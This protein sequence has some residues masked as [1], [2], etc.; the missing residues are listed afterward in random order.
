[1]IFGRR[2]APVLGFLTL[3]LTS[4]QTPESIIGPPEPGIAYVPSVREKIAIE[5][6]VKRKLKDPGSAVIG[7]IGAVETPN[8]IR[9]ACGLVNARNSYGGYTGYVPFYGLFQHKPNGE[10]IFAVIGLSSSET[11]QIATL[12]M[13]EKYDL[14]YHPPG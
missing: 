6:G 13:C 8:G 7:A 11:G 12:M 9:H 1:M 10:L 4:C 5:L 2:C 14:N 3:A